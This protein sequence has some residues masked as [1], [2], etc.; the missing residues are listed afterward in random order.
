MDACTI[1]GIQH[2]AEALVELPRLLG[3][4]T[5]GGMEIIPGD[6]T[7]GESGTL[8]ASNRGDECTDPTMLVRK[9]RNKYH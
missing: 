7:D 3:F 4:S 5:T 8:P 6:Q 1:C 9:S 2:A